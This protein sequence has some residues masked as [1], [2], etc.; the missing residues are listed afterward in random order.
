MQF[1]ERVFHLLLKSSGGRGFT[2]WSRD[3][4]IELHFNTQFLFIFLEKKVSRLNQSVV[5]ALRQSKKIILFYDKCNEVLVFVLGGRPC[6]QRERSSSNQVSQSIN[7]S[8]RQELLLQKVRH[9]CGRLQT[10]NFKIPL[11]SF[12]YDI[13]GNLEVYKFLSS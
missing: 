2:I 6:W 3:R 4:F 7:C 9:L 11:L 1:C 13:I 5:K 8:Q 10:L 12:V